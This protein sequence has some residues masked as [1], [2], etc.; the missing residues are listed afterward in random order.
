MNNTPDPITP[1]S[2]WTPTTSTVGGGVLG[3]A[4]AQIIVAVIEALSHQPLTSQL[5]G[6]ITTL[7]V[8]IVGYFFPD[9]GRK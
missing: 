5:T 7:S 9:G 2:G 1:V 6:A 4:V 3:G 8:V